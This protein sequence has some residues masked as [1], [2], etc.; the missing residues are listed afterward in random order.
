MDIYWTIC[1]SR[2]AFF[3]V[4]M[5]PKCITFKTRRSF[6]NKGNHLNPLTGWWQHW[7]TTPGCSSPANHFQIIN[8]KRKSSFSPHLI[9]PLVPQL[10]RDFQF[11]A[12]VRAKPTWRV[13][14]IREIFSLDI[15]FW[16][17]H[18]LFLGFNDWGLSN[19]CN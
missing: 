18:H 19:M 6:L 11:L 13:F 7:Q 14:H 12:G 9:H 1:G 5:Y 17:T 15:L 3:L 10:S 8:L 2:N 4:L 16:I